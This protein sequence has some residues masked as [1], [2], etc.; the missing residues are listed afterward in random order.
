MGEGPRPLPLPAPDTSA[1]M[2]TATTA[3][4]AGGGGGGGGDVGDGGTP[5]HVPRTWTRQRVPSADGWDSVMA[6]VRFG[7]G[8]PVMTAPP[9]TTFLAP[10]HATSVDA[11]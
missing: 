10:G 3:P 6:R 8:P 1:Q 7:H 5:I 11:A 4:G 2:A 9:P